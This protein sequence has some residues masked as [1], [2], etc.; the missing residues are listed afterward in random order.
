MHH[1]VV[2][3]LLLQELAEQLKQLTQ[4]QQ[5]LERS[6]ETHE[7]T[8]TRLKQ[9]LEAVTSG[10]VAVEEQLKVVG[11]EKQA[12]ATSLALQQVRLHSTHGWHLFI[13]H[14]CWQTATRLDNRSSVLV[15]YAACK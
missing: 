4:Q 1:D 7:G 3:L 13:G 9:E 11:E 2:E 8:A 12:L 5:T 10:K 14:P 6:A 15:P